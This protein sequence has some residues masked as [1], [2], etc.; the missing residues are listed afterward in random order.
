VFAFY[1]VGL[2]RIVS[3]AANQSEAR[4]EAAAG[5]VNSSMLAALRF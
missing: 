4:A 2:Y 5:L 1:A 3:G